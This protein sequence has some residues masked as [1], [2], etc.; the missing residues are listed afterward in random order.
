MTPE[1]F[2]KLD[3]AERE[4]EIEHYNRNVR[5]WVVICRKCGFKNYGTLQE[6]EGKPCGACGN[7]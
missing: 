7:G 2:E 4:R 5:T 3:R 6:L 1:E